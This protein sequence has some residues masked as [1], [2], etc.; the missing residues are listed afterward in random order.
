MEGEIYRPVRHRH[1][2]AILRAAP[3]EQT[4]ITRITSN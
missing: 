4:P 2:D 3:E 1:I